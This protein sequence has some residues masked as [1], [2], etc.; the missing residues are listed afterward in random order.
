MMSELAEQDVTQN[1]TNFL[2]SRPV[3]LWGEW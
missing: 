2:I 3:T 1:T